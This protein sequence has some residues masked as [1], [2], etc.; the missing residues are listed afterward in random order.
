MAKTI[1]KKKVPLTDQQKKQNKLRKSI[2]SFI[3]SMGFEYLRTEGKN[4]V[5][6]GQ[7]GELD[8]VYLF[9][10]IV[11]VCE[12]TIITTDI[13]DHI[14]KKDFF[15]QKIEENKKEFLE[16]LTT[17]Y[18]DK[19]AK[20][21]SY[22]VPRYKIFYLY[23]YTTPI[24]L[25]TKDLFPRIK[26]IDENKLNYFVSVASNLKLSA[27]NEMYRFLKINHSDV[28]IAS[29]S[30]PDS[31]IETAVILPEDSSGFSEG[32]KVVSFMMCAEDL[33]ECAYVLRKEDW[34]SQVEL[35]QRLVISTKIK[36][37][38]DFIATSKK[39]F[40]NNIIVSLPYN[41]KFYDPKD[42]QKEIDLDHISEIKNLM[43]TIPRTINSICIIDGQHR[44]FA[45][46]KANDKSENEISRIRK[47]RHLLVTGLVFPKTMRYEERVQFESGIFL[48]INSTQKAVE[49]SLLQHIQSIK[50]PYSPTATAR[51]VLAEMNERDPFLSHFQFY[52]F[53]TKKIRI[54]SIVEYGLTDLVEISAEKDTLFK[55]WDNDKKNILIS[56][57][58][59]EDFDKVYREYISFCARTISL[60]FNAVKANFKKD[61][62]LD[63]TSKLLSVISITGFIISLRKSLE[64]Y[65]EVHNYEFYY[66]K[67][68]LLKMDF[69]KENFP[70]T[71]SL[72]NKF[73][74]DIKAQCWEED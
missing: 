49:P 29:S 38:R 61:W 59:S 68:S 57:V 70:Y 34:E 72:Y 73:A 41:V 64:V 21:N 71:S 47:R 3:K 37:M 5:F 24:E 9:E 8:S 26:F 17:E 14:R 45:H 48:E 55:Y 23:F 7:Q 25:D 50:T 42:P 11:L 4:K 46:H 18:A 15:Y 35:Y 33:M 22:A 19:F 60:F 44:I 20:F 53:E 36:K 43:M 28:G 27:I 66:K 31:R 54:Y 39:T 74:E 62:T 65:K 51:K 16:W 69:S 63:K 10:N 67:L 32:I 52:S 2:Q 1:R 40:I 56:K 6:G 12:D 30:T 58:Y 13:K